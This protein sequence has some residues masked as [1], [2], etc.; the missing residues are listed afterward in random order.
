MLTPDGRLRRYSYPDFRPQDALRLGGLAY[1]AAYD[2]Q[3]GRLY[4]A[5]IDPEALRDRP[6]AKGFGD[7][8]VYDLRALTA[9]R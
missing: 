9:R 7:I 3:T 8:H 1:G 5:L 6:R 4:V 2:V